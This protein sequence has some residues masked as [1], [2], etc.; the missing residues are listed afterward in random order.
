MEKNTYKKRSSF[1]DRIYFAT[2][3]PTAKLALL[4]SF[5]RFHIIPNEYGMIVLKLD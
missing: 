4:A 5:F 1:D 3:G 2:I